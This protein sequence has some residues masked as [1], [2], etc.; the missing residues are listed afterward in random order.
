M[1]YALANTMEAVDAGAVIVDATVQGM[2]RGP[3]NVRTVYVV[4]ELSRRK[5][6]HAK[7]V[8]LVTLV[9]RDFAEMKRDFGWG[10]NL[11]Y[12]QSAN[13]AVHPTYVMELTKDG[14]YPPSQIVDTL[15]H[16]NE[17]GG[18]QFDRN[19]LV[20][21][22]A[23]RT[24]SYT[25]STDVAG[26]CAHRDVVIVGPGAEARTKKSEI[27]QFIKQ[28]NVLAIGLGAFSA[29]DP[30]LIS[31]VA[32]CHPE[33]AVLEASGL[34]ALTCPVY[35][36]GAMLAEHN[37]SVRSLHDVGV[38]TGTGAF[39]GTATTLEIPRLLSAAYA[40]ALAAKG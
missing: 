14:R 25:G 36:P 4:M 9:E 33:R 31:A 1:S 10:S 3:G 12:F 16:L 40:L 15:E 23:G 38:V 27:E 30:A 39:G 26:W 34:T 18:A 8:P 21:I 13:L 6:S 29:I 22:T 11:Y 24:V 7:A 19:R 17:H 20:G 37:I 5:Q 32:V 28:H 35:A 2:G